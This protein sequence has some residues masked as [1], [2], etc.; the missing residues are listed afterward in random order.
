MNNNDNGEMSSLEFACYAIF[1]AG[2]MYVA[3]IWISEKLKK[4]EVKQAD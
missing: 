3:D 1:F 4:Q 2:I